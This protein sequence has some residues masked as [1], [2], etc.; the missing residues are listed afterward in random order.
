MSTL[1][2][3]YEPVFQIMKLSQIL[4]L[5][6]IHKLVLL[7][8]TKNDEELRLENSKERIFFFN[9]RWVIL[10]EWRDILIIIGLLQRGAYWYLI[11][12]MSTKLLFSQ[13]QQ[14]VYL[15]FF[16]SVHHNYYIDFS[17]MSLLCSLCSNTILLFWFFR[18]F[19]KI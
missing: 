18:K 10:D 16:L 6:F 5:T 13:N 2:I 14:R 12:Q 19:L 8:T 1:L 11:V 7:R 15:D 3:N 4:R 17:E 9:F